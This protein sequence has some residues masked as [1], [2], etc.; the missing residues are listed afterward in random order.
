MNATNGRELSSS[1]R[2]WM[3]HLRACDASGKTMRAYAAE[4]G[5]SVGSL[6]G[7]KKR[8]VRNGLISGRRDVAAVRFTRASIA[9][10]PASTLRIDLPNGVSVSCSGSVNGATLTTVLRAAATL[11]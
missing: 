9:T 1:E 10:P 7:A 3:E 6:Y 11:G 2:R 5:I 4:A 8:L